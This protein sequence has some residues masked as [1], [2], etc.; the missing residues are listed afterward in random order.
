MKEIHNDGGT[1]EV[2]C[3]GGKVRALFI[4]TATMK[5]HLKKHKPDLIQLD[6][7]FGTNKQRYKVGAFVYPCRRT[8]KTRVAAFSLLADERE[9]NIQFMISSFKKVFE[10][11]LYPTVNNII[12]ASSPQQNNGVD[13]G[14]FAIANLI[15]LLSNQQPVSNI[16]YTNMRKTVRKMLTDK[17]ISGFETVILRGAKR[18]PEKMIFERKLA[19]IQELK[20]LEFVDACPSKGAPKGKRQRRYEGRFNNC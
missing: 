14:L 3:E 13:C 7:T 20:K 11:Q 15:T 6:T 4:S 18:K 12:L 9:P 16:S 1:C 19:S 17:Q 5:N 8:N 10:E 2:R